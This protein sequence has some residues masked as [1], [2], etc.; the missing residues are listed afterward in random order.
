MEQATFANGCFWCTEAIFRRV[1]GVTNVQSGYAGGKRENPSYDQVVTGATGHAEAIQL[2]FDPTLI[3][4]EVLLDIFWHLHNPT[5]KD[6]EGAD[7]GTE[8]RSIIFYHNEKQHKVAEQ[9]KKALDA[10]G[11]YSAPIVTEI[12]PYT[13]FYTAEKY[14]QEFYEKNSYVPYCQYVIDPKV[15]KLLEKYSK[16]VK[17][18]YLHK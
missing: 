14:H 5:S 17:K 1:L 8:Y 16:Y 4:Y 7:R 10:S 6:G 13:S 18:E 11:E 15:N 9:S 2:T 12:L 3:S